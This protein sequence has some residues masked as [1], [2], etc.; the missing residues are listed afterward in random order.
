MR[1]DDSSCRRL[2][3]WDTFLLESEEAVLREMQ[4]YSDQG[5]ELFL[6][7]LVGKMQEVLQSRY[8]PQ[9]SYKVHLVDDNSINAAASGAQIFVNRGTLL[10]YMDPLHFWGEQG[11]DPRTAR[12]LR[13]QVTPWEEDAAGLAFIVA[14]EVGHNVL[15]H[16]PNVAGFICQ[17]HMA[18]VEQANQRAGK[19]AAKDEELK[20]HGK[21]VG[22]WRKFGRALQTG[23][24][25][26]LSSMLNSIEFVQ[27]QQ[28]AE[29]EADRLG[30]LILREI[31]LDPNAGARSLGHLA[32]IHGYADGNSA[33]IKD[34]LCSDHP[35]IL[36]RISRAEVLAQESSVRSGS[37]GVKW[38]TPA[39]LTPTRI[40]YIYSMSGAAF[41]AGD[42]EQAL[43]WL[44]V[45]LEYSAEDP[46]LHY[47]RACV[48][49]RLGRSEE[50]LGVLRRVFDHEPDLRAHAAENID[51]E[52]LRELTQ[53]KELVSGD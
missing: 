22:F 36:E 29:Y 42:F 37:T 48:L 53:F 24:S 52:S 19:R 2:F 16:P 18:A 33:I 35:H 11:Q 3:E 43:R 40:E 30:V 47:N 51:L 26:S 39:D 20:A 38:P 25:E 44:D 21:K 31:G 6:S 5:Y 34:F 4:L 46:Y 41:G 9:P 10:F 17:Q 8:G 12:A 1:I 13:A 49:A 14:H 23:T 28:E 15:A 7:D 50:A 27:Y 32:T 45:G